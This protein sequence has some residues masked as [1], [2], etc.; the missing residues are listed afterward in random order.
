M[1]WDAGASIFPHLPPR[2][3]AV[4]VVADLVDD[5][6][7]TFWRAMLSERAVMDK[8]RLF[9]YMGVNLL[10]ERYCMRRTAHCI[11]V[12]E[13]DAA[14]F[15]KV[16]PKVPVSVI[17]NG[18]D[19]DFFTPGNG[20]TY[21]AGWSSK[22]RW[23]SFP[24]S[25]RPFFWST[26]SCRISGPNGQTPALRWLAAIRHRIFAPWE[27]TVSLS[28]ERSRIFAPMF[29]GAGVCLPSAIRC[30]NQEQALAG[31]GYGQG[32]RCHQPQCRWVGRK[33]W[34]NLLIRDDVEAIASAVL[35]LLEKPSQRDSLGERG[36]A[37]VENAFTWEAQARALMHCFTST[38]RATFIDGNV[39]DL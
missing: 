24:T 8:L 14:V 25:R 22:A 10:F 39:P 11:V 17:Q 15:R 2:W 1:I 7:L 26:R 4:P 36:R 3:D 21:P 19:V 20:T 32:S 28:L 23:P 35:E 30:G 38:W 29:G 12:S 33:R 37:T 27:A 16:S 13:D 34:D 18:V 6:V 9:K 31:L 5:M